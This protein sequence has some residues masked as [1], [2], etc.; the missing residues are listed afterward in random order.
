[1]MT[2][3]YETITI[4]L[5]NFFFYLLNGLLGIQLWKEL[6]EAT[7]INGAFI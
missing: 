6:G 5:Y 1:M 4:P 2:V 7:K 3:Q